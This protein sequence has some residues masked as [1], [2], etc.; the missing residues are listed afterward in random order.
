MAQMKKQAVYQNATVDLAA[1]TVTEE[2]EYETMTYRIA[3]IFR[4]WDGVPGVT[5]T[6]SAASAITK[7]GR[8]AWG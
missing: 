5:L 2:L 1:E 3:D 6:I 8:G 4:E 7:D